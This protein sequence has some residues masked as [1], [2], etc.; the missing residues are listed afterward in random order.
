MPEPIP[1]GRRSYDWVFIVFLLMFALFSFLGDMTVAIG[2]PAPDSGW[3]M[4][5]L[6]FN[7]YALNKDLLVLHDPVFMRVACFFAAFIFGPFQLIAAWAFYKGHDWIRTP[8]LIYAGALFEGSFIVIWAQIFGDKEFFEQVCPGAGFDFAAQDLVW[9]LAF[10][11]WYIV[12][13]LLL[14]GRLWR[15]HPFGNSVKTR[16][17]IPTSA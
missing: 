12:I 15:E 3:F 8:A 16:Y 5:R 14:M 6:I 11:I 9:V 4:R 10:N 13:P 17:A 1:I 7:V 2:R